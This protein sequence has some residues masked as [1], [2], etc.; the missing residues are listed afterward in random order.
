MQETSAIVASSET[1]SCEEAE[2]IAPTELEEGLP[3]DGAHRDILD[4][5]PADRRA[6]ATEFIA[7]ALG[8]QTEAAGKLA[9]LVLICAQDR[10]GSPE[11]IVE[12]LAVAERHAILKSGSLFL[13]LGHMLLAA[14]LVEPAMR[15]Y[16]RATELH[17][18]NKWHAG[19]RLH[20]FVSGQ[21]A[22]AATIA[23]VVDALDG[24]VDFH[25]PDMFIS[26]LSCAAEFDDFDMT[27]CQ[28]LAAAV[29][30][31]RVSDIGS[32]LLSNG[33][34]AAAL[35][36]YDCAAVVAPE[37]V[38]LRLQMGITEFLAGRYVEAERQWALTAYIRANTR[39]NWGLQNHNL[40][41]LGTSWFAAIGHVACIDTYIKSM[42][43]GWRKRRPTA[44]VFDQS[45]PPPGAALLR[46]WSRYIDIHNV[47]GG[48]EALDRK[49]NQGLINSAEAMER[50][51]IGYPCDGDADKRLHSKRVESLTEDFWYGPDGEGRI[52]WYAPLGAEV[53]RAWKAAGCGPLLVIEEAE[54]VATRKLLKQVFGLPEDAWFVALHVRE[55]GFHASWHKSHPGT[56]HADISTY[57]R[58]ID[59][60]TRAGGWVIR[61]GD[62]SMKPIEPRAQ[63]IDYATSSFR[64]FELDVFLCGDCKYFIGTN[65]GLSL[66]PPL[67]GRRCVLTNW[68]PI[69]IPNWYLDDIY[70]PKLVRQ[71]EE[72]RHL[73]FREMYGSVAGWTQWLR[74]YP[75]G[76]QEIEDNDADDLI[77]AVQELH[78]EVVVG[79]AHTAE[80]LALISKYN[81]IAVAG[82]SYIGSRIGARF[83]KKYQHLLDD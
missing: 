31:S 40:R 79:K 19:Q 71:V 69:A 5:L 44:F 22:D 59:L 12:T 38:S 39:R 73:S 11:K 36:V 28:G 77:D 60:V 27:R 46:R 49:P 54:R 57:D 26:V 14:G 15:A 61:L 10:A 78:D 64:N 48:A 3:F 21:N 20:D 63:V 9:H 43:L 47:A 6:E 58:V 37:E 1:T 16:V 68:S 41:F 55:P 45:K 53:E 23:V 83:L 35:R 25:V 72:N 82:G 33:N 75:E 18:D 76:M 65:S 29:G 52:R 62:R 13:N 74:D 7:S 81:E 51:L 2:A 56:R 67:F 42:E 30:W 8:K 66:L 70:I 32:K 24:A 80:E 34:H 50:K 17:T 4:L